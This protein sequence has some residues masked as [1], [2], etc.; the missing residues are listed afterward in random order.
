MSSNNLRDNFVCPIS[1]QLFN[2][3][4]LAEDGYFYEESEIR[5]WLKTNDKSPMTNIYMGK[6]LRCSHLISSLL[7]KFYEENP[8]DLDNRFDIDDQ[9]DILRNH[10]V[11]KDYWKIMEFVNIDLGYFDAGLLK[12][13]IING[14][15]QIIK[16]LIDNASNI[17]VEYSN[18]WKLIHY[19]CR[20]SKPKMVKYI[21]DRGVDL[22]CENRNKWRPIH[23]ICRYSTPKMIKYIIDKGVDLECEDRSKW[24]PIHFICRYST[25]EMMKYIIDKGVDLECEDNE[26]WR[27]IHFICKYSTAEMVKY[28]INEGVDLECMNQKGKTPFDLIPNWIDKMNIYFHM[29]LI[30]GF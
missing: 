8:C 10:I 14:S 16:H 24:R 7:E 15:S 25:P 23:F 9:M 5:K 19:I 22:E 13:I 29:N 20:Y 12:E 17:E 6:S 11:N 18:K 1:C 26:N 21:I 3:P 30:C 4:V 27:P 2:K 28:I